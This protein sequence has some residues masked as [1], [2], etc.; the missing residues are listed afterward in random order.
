MSTDTQPTPPSTSPPTVEPHPHRWW[1]LVVLAIAQL[2]VVLDAT[3]VNIALPAAQAD[4]GFDDDLR[5]WVVTAYSLAFGGLLLLGGRINDQF[6]RKQAFIIGLVGFAAASALGGWSPTFEVLVIARA[7]QGVFGA[8][9]APAALSLLTVTFSHS[10]ERGRAFGI[11]GAISGA[12]GA[13]GLLLGGVL[14]EYI[15]W[16]WC[17]YVN[18]IFAVIALVAAVKLIPAH[19]P[20][21]AAGSLDWPGTVTATFGLFALVYGLANSEV[22]GWSDTWTITFIVVGA[23]LLAAFVVIET[24]VVHPLL[25]L[26]VVLDRVRGTSY[27]VMFIA[28]IGMFGVFLFLTYYLQGTLGY[29]PV[30]TGVAFLPMVAALALTAAVVG[31]VTQKVSPKILVGVGLALSACAML[32]LTTIDVDSSYATGV[33]PGLLMFGIG[34]GSVFATAMG[35][36]TSGVA[37]EDAGVASATVNTAQQVGGSMG[38]SL[39]S[40]F[41]AT[42][43]ADYVTAHQPGPTATP[44]ALLALEHGTQLASYHTAFWWSAGFFAVGAVIAALLYPAKPPKIDAETVVIAH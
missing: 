5:Q 12:G 9:L 29:S 17:L 33:L 14:T 19:K 6:G 11:Y 18:V 22:N 8:L 30:A 4:L 42:A 40:S 2:M 39:L 36:A 20:D 35:F 44:E 21:D 1:I 26:R 43:A 27:I 15:S 37:A 13:I 10:G 24:K 3:I 34:L 25:P 16:N 7:L 28:A 38:I 32:F 23:V 41:A 31:N